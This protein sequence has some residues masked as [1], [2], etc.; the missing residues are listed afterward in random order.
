LELAEMPKQEILVKKAIEKEN[1]WRGRRH[2]EAKYTKRAN[3]SKFY[4]SKQTFQRIKQESLM[5][6]SVC[7]I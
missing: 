6:F 5:Q 2:E 4:I 7:H 3:I 1:E